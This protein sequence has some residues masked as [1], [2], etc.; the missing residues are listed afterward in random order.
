MSYKNYVTLNSDYPSPLKALREADVQIE[1]LLLEVAQ[2]VQNQLRS[3][4]TD[5]NRITYY[6]RGIESAVRQEFEAQY[7]VMNKRLCRQ[8]LHNLD[9]FN[10]AAEANLLKMPIEHV[11]VEDKLIVFEGNALPEDSDW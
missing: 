10:G 7:P 6:Y 2:F 1:E 11:R 9:F 3:A 5:S 8:L 4:N